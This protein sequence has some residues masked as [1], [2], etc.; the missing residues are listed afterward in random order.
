MSYLPHQIEDVRWWSET[1]KR[2]I[3]AW[4]VGTGKTYVGA[5]MCAKEAQRNKR[6]LVVAPPSL[7]RSWIEEC[8][9][10]GL[11][12]EPAWKRDGIASIVTYDRL[13]YVSFRR[14]DLV[15]A[16]EAHR[17]KNHMRKRAKLFRAIAQRTAQVLMMTGTLSNYRDPMELL[18]YLWCLNNDSS[19]PYNITR[20]R[21][22]YCMKKRVSATTEIFVSKP[23]GKH[24]I[25]NAIAR[26]SR[27]RKLR[28]VQSLP[29]LIEERRYVK[30][31]LDLTRK[32]IEASIA[33]DL[34]LDR[35][36]INYGSPHICH[37]LMMANGWD[38]EEHAL[39]ND[40]KITAVKEAIEDIGDEQCIIWVYWRGFAE[41]M[42]NALGDDC[43][44]VYG[45]TSQKQKE[46]AIDS[47]KNGS[48]KY[49]VASM[50][51]IAEGHNLQNCR[52]SIIANQWYDIIKDIQSRGRIERIGQNKTMVQIRI[53]GE[54]TVEEDVMSV[55][56]KKMSLHE[57]QAYLNKRIEERY[58]NAR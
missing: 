24:L 35:I 39:Y 52:Y 55:L 26:V 48:V 9:S 28:E 25:D 4:E 51:S 38:H 20:Y 23:S 14:Y 6:V 40:A 17:I 19:I 56:D 43:R 41:A 27:V 12:L 45:G 53:I 32:K 30:S 58:R 42:A 11:I 50:G 16:D 18:N 13:K 46:N 54:G 36:D 10:V 37:A 1:G 15:I 47:F 34:D 2:G 8:A 44:L 5:R 3:F 29:E 22:D 31:G 49:L 57:A 7:V 33:L 21:N